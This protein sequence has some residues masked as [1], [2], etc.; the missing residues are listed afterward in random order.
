M[1]AFPTCKFPRELGFI[2]AAANPNFWRLPPAVC[3][4]LSAVCLLP[5][6]YGMGLEST[7]EINSLRPASE[8]L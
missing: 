6:T 1:P 5:L 2:N 4:L 3:L 8:L 7:V